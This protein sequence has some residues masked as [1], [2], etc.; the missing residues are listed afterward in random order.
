MIIYYSEVCHIYPLL[1]LKFLFGFDY[2]LYHHKGH[3]RYRKVKQQVTKLYSQLL[4]IAE[5][6]EFDHLCN[7]TFYIGNMYLKFIDYKVVTLHRILCNGIVSGG[8]YNYRSF[9]RF[10]GFV[11][12]SANDDKVCSPSV[13]FNDVTDLKGVGG[14][15]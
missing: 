6:G 1:L 9:R 7:I 3:K 4:F 14:D 10:K 11:D 13:E 8:G 12:I 15:R 5:H 2:T